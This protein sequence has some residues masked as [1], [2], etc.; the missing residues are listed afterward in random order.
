MNKNS[1]SAM[2]DNSS[3]EGNKKVYNTIDINFS[4]LSKKMLPTSPS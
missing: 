1:G 2:S 3:K 4:D